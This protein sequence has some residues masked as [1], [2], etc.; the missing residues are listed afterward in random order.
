MDLQEQLDRAI[1]QGPPLPPPERRLEAGRAAVRRRRTR[2]ATAV[3]AV[4]VTVMA[5][6]TAL[7]LSRPTAHDA[8]GPAVSPSSATRSPRPSDGSEPG[9]VEDVRVVVVDG[10]PELVGHPARATI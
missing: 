6:A 9:A 2:A 8:V 4:A 7:T 10:V 5:S 3:V 1:G